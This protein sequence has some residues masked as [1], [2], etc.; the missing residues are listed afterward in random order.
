MTS[1]VYA[2]LPETIDEACLASGLYEKAPKS[3]THTPQC[4]SLEPLTSTNSA[5]LKTDLPKLPQNM[6]TFQA[7]WRRLLEWRAP[8]PEAV[9]VTFDL[10]KYS[11]PDLFKR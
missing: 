7:Q 10:T 3:P 9:K 8:I 2:G 1:G 11:D 6:A 4:M 5:R